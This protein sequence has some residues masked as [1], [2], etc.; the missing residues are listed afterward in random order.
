MKKQFRLWA[1]CCS[2]VGTDL[3]F[4]RESL[5]DAIRQSEDGGEEG[6][7]PFDWD[8]AVVL[9]DHSGGQTTPTDEEG[10]EI[11]R[12]FGVSAKHPREH[13]YTVVG[14]HDAPIE[15]D[16][17]LQWWARKWIDP[18]GEDPEHSEVH[19]DRMPYAVDGTWERYTFAVGNI[20]FLMMSDRN[21]FPP[22]VGRRGAT[23]G[24]YP[25]GAVTSE[26]FDWWRRN[27]WR[28]TRTPF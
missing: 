23:H 1:T 21:D 17:P 26:T 25:S 12:Q 8:I 13:F 6:G 20:R 5:A 4:G 10:R 9:G 14:N 15:V 7:H 22:P 11:V 24:G 27:T 19:A 28:Q 16:A 18:T 3:G 2:H